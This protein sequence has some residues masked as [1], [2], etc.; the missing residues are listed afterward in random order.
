MD[1]DF[2][3]IRC[4]RVGWIPNPPFQYL[5]NQ[6]NISIDFKV[7]TISLNKKDVELINHRRRFDRIIVRMKLVI[8]G[9]KIHDSDTELKKGWINDP[10]YRIIVPF[11][12]FPLS[13]LGF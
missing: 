1:Y 2:I 9:G 11:P 3:R 4:N 13:T 12:L 5:T 7:K 6:Y 10:P 8:S